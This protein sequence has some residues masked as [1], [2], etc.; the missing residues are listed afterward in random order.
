M[1]RQPQI[2]APTPLMAPTPHTAV[3]HRP[4]WRTNARNGAATNLHSGTTPCAVHRHPA[5]EDGALTTRIG[6]TQTAATLYVHP[7]V[8]RARNS[9]SVPSLPLERSCNALPALDIIEVNLSPSRKPGRLLALH[10][11]LPHHLRSLICASSS[12]VCV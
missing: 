7:I 5:N 12:S 8:E 11:N 1:R 3:R 4:A 2:V 6:L 10:Q 9:G